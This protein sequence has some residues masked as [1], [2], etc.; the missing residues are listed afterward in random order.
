MEDRK[1][2]KCTRCGIMNAPHVDQCRCLPKQEDK[3]DNR[4]VLTEKLRG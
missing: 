3:R 4:R 2:W 1:P